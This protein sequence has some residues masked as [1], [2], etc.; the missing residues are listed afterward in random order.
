LKRNKILRLKFA[1]TLGYFVEVIYFIASGV[2]LGLGY[3]AFALI[4]FV[5]ASAMAFVV[6]KLII[7][8]Y[9]IKED[10][11]RKKAERMIKKKKKGGKNGRK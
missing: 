3:F 11:I 9:R 6:G 8:N 10:M 1:E 7:L 5:I 2:A 4:Y